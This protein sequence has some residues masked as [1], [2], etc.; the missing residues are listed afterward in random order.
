MPL[1]VRFFKDTVI[2]DAGKAQE[3]E[4]IETT[5]PDSVTQSVRV[6]T[7]EDRAKYVAEYAEF[8]EA[9]APQGKKGD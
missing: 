2:N 3:R 7:D 6:A 1:P 9:N 5:H 4:L 8:V